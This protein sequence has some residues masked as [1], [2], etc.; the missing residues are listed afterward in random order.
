MISS[1]VKYLTY[2]FSFF[3]WQLKMIPKIYAVLS[4][5]SKIS[6]NLLIDIIWTISRYCLFSLFALI[7]IHQTYSECMTRLNYSNSCQLGPFWTMNNQSGSISS[8]MTLKSFLALFPLGYMSAGLLSLCWGTSLF[9]SRGWIVDFKI[10]LK[11][12]FSV[13]L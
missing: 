6:S 11:C 8:Q 2:I 7:S 4:F 12:T 1:K 3:W 5:T 10:F 13:I 9:I